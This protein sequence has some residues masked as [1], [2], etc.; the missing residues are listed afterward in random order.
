MKEPLEHV[1]TLY[2]AGQQNKDWRSPTICRFYSSVSLLTYVTKIS[3][4]SWM[5]SSI[6]AERLSKDPKHDV[7]NFKSD[8]C[9]KLAIEPNLVKR[10]RRMEQKSKRAQPMA[11]NDLG[12]SLSEANDGDDL[13]QDLGFGASPVCLASHFIVFSLLMGFLAC[14]F[15]LS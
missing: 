9:S 3:G 2:S 11:A 5:L 13:L 6:E 8:D 10:V 12:L 15:P 7:I 14:A 4:H 1:A